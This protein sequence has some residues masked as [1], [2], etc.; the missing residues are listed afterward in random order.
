ME[1]E[2]DTEDVSLPD[3]MQREWQE[4]LD[5]LAGLMEVPAAL[6]MKASPSFVEVF[7]ASQTEENPYSVGETQDI[8][9]VYCEKVI[10]S[11]EKLFVRDALQTE[12]WKDNP[13]I[14]LG[15]ICYL[16]FPIELAIGES[17]WDPEQDRSVE[18][19]IQKADSKMYA[20]KQRQAQENPGC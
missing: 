7:G 5:L 9:G 11:K 4:M 6:I 17:I 8:A 20:E 14:E 16:G 2:V 18:D 19:V 13:D 12:K 10:H 15:M 1:I 3:H